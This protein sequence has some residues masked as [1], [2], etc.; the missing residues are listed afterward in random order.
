MRQSTEP[1]ACGSYALLSLSAR[2]ARSKPNRKRDGLKRTRPQMA[3]D[4]MHMTLHSLA[5]KSAIAVCQDRLYQ[6]KY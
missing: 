3:Y 2:V 1:S 6:R 4:N 5:W